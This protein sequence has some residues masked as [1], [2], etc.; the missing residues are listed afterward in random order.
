MAENHVSVSVQRGDF[1]PVALQCGLLHD[2]AGAVVTFTGYVKAGSDA[3][4][5]AIEL[6]HYPGMTEQSITAIGDQA[7]RRWP[8]KAITVVHR[9]GHLRVGEQIVWVGASATHR[10]DAFAACEFVMDYLKTQAPF[11]KREL[12]NFGQRWVEAKSAD[13][14]RAERWHLP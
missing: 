10:G 13:Q 12:G 2:D 3:T 1:D 6:E 11:W 8:V 4:I 5:T 7:R 9:V 14:T